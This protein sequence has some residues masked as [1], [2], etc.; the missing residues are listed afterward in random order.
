VGNAGGG[1]SVSCRHQIGGGVKLS[2][3]VSMSR[4]GGEKMTLKL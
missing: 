4:H 1:G 2:A 3:A